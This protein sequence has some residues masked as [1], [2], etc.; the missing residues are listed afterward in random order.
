MPFGTGIFFVGVRLG[1]VVSIAGEIVD[2][3]VDL[4]EAVFGH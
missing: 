3:L 2:A 1:A 4:R